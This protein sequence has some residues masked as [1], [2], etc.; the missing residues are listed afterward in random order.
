MN[1]KEEYLQAKHKLRKQKCECKASGK[2]FS[3]DASVW[4]LLDIEQEEF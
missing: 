4:E 1:V 3:Y 2:H